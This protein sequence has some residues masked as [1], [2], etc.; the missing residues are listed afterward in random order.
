MYTQTVALKEVRCYAFHGYYPEE[1]LTGGVFLVDAEVTFEAND[2]TE[3]LDKTVNY[4]V[5]NAIILQEMSNTQKLLETVVK[6]II[7][8]ITSK[9][10]FIATAKVGIKKMNPP[11]EG[12]IGYSFVQLGFVA[13]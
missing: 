9:Y 5:L 11:M 2:D 1:Q 10:P 12:E 13:D 6:R 3:N 7:D 8:S 4:E